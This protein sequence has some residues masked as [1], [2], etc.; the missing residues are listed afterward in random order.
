LGRPPVKSSKAVAAAQTKG[1]LEAETKF[2]DKQPLQKKLKRLLWRK[3]EQIDPIKLG[4]LLATTYAVHGIVTTL[5]DN[6]KAKI[7]RWEITT[8]IA[9]PFAATLAEATIFSRSFVEQKKSS[10]GELN[11]WILS[12][13]VAYILIEHGGEILGILADGGKSIGTMVTALVA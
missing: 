1:R 7:L 13:V 9:G 6:T 11:Y 5:D 4:A 3:L 2:W 12:F 10:T 8:I